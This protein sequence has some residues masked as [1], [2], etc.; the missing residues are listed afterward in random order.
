MA[1]E[2]IT[3]EPAPISKGWGAEVKHARVPSGMKL[4][5]EYDEDAILRFLGKKDISDRVKPKEG[6]NP[7]RKV[8]YLSF[9]DGKRVVSMASSHAMTEF[10][11]EPG[12]WYYLH[13]EDEIEVS[14][15]KG[16][17]KMKDFNI[18]QLGVSGETVQCPERVHPSGGIVLSDA[19]VR[20]ANYTRLNYPLR[21]PRK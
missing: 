6:E 21:E 15:V 8:I 3:P 12:F 4:I 14:H 1:K 17:N 19:S 7:D 2:N 13:N 16:Y 18:L 11:F 20:E 10:E 9:F 5:F